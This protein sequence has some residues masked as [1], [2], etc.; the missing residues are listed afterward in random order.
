MHKAASDAL[1]HAWLPE[2]L[3]ALPLPPIQRGKD[4]RKEGAIGRP[5]CGMAE[6]VTFV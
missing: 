6:M 5:A 2:N 4:E 3:R 1:T